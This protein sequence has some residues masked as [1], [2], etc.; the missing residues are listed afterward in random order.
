MKALPITLGLLLWQGINPHIPEVHEHVKAPVRKSKE[1]VLRGRV[2]DES[3]QPLAGIR[4]SAVREKD[5]GVINGLPELSVETRS[6]STGEYTFP[7]LLSG[8]YQICA[9][10]GFPRSCTIVGWRADVCGTRRMETHC[11]RPH[12]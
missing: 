2:T 1:L 11:N 5:V 7:S 9:G 4:V 8:S 12:S 3:K 6:A 10:S